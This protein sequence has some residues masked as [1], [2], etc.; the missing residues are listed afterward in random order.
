MT[1]LQTVTEYLNNVIELSLN[2]QWMEWKYCLQLPVTAQAERA[3]Q[4]KNELIRFDEIMDRIPDRSIRNVLGLRYALGISI[5]D[6]AYIMDTSKISV[7]RLHKRG[8]DMIEHSTGSDAGT[9]Q[10]RENRSQEHHSDHCRPP[11]R[12]RGTGAAAAGVLP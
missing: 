12:I 6:T 3:A 4:L 1:D 10:I 9:D 11:N 5:A 7:I 8:M 2:R